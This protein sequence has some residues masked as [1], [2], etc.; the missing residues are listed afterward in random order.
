V[1]GV[2]EEGG[3]P[4]WF[5]A[6][7]SLPQRL[8]EGLTGT[9]Q[10]EE[11]PIEPGS[12]CDGRQVKEIPWP[13]HFVI[14][15]LRRGAQIIIQKGDTRLCVGDILTVVGEAASIHEVRLICHKD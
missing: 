11:I 3:G 10:V 12:A 14:A 13:E 1:D 6:Q 4:F 5:L 8:K 2:L 15:S 7:E 9:A